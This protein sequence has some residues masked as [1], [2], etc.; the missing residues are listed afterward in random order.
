MSALTLAPRRWYS[1]DFFSVRRQTGSSPISISR[2]GGKKACC[3]S[4]AWTT[5][6]LAR[7]RWGISFSSTAG[8]TLARATKP[9]AFQR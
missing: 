8:S 5:A 6:S 4:R 2:H 7:A 3:R 1:W 9:S